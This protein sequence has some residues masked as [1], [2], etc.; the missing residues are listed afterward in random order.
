MKSGKRVEWGW[1]KNKMGKGEVNRE[2]IGNVFDRKLERVMMYVVYDREYVDKE[3]VIGN[4][5]IKSL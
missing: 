4:V 2:W 5:L 1:K 3:C